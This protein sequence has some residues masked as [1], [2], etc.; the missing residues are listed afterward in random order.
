MTKVCFLFANDKRR[1]QNSNVSHDGKPKQKVIYFDIRIIQ[2][3]R[4]KQK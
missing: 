4:A 2:G 1:Y 3:L